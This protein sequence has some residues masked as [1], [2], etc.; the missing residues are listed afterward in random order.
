MTRSLDG[1]PR[2]LSQQQH[3]TIRNTLQVTHTCAI[4]SMCLTHGKGGYNAGYG[5]IPN[6]RGGSTRSESFDRYHSP[7]YQAQGIGSLQSQ[8]G[9]AYSP[10][11]LEA[12]S[13]LSEKHQSS[14]ITEAHLFGLSV[15][16]RLP[17]IFQTLSNRRCVCY[18][19]AYF[20]ILFK[21]WQIGKGWLEGIDSPMNNEG[22]YFRGVA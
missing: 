15:A 6:S 4:L 18:L 12:V 19:V 10:R 22:I 11:R 20:T 2:G 17:I 3:A 5:R 13:G 21:Q 9:L 1:V 16:H 7:A 14:R 8:R